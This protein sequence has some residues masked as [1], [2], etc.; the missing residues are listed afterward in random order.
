MTKFLFVADSRGHKFSNYSKP[1]DKA[2]SFTVNF[3]AIRGAKMY[4][5][6]GPTIRKLNSC[7]ASDHIV[8]QLAAGINDLTAFQ[9]NVAHERR[10]LKPSNHTAESVFQELNQ[11]KSAI[12]TA[13]PNT[14]VTFA[15]IPP[16]SFAKF[17]SSKKLCAP[18]ISKEDIHTF[19]HHHDSI[20]DEVNERIITHNSIPQCGI[21]L[22]TLSWH[23]TIRKVEKRTRR[24]KITHS[25]R[26]HFVHAWR[27]KIKAA[28]V[29]R[30]V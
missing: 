16:M 20:V 4:N 9:Y 25:K 3:V 13:R 10:V 7:N 14:L 17:Q 29:F 2:F 27:L 15:T 11:F 1:V 12:Q 21:V 23:N 22:R 28:L 6:V 24:N 5:L 19:Q 30:N 8:V 18:I 26:N